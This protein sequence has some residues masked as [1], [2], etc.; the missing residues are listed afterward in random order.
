MPTLSRRGLLALGGAGAAGALLAACG[1]AVDP[2]ADGDDDGAGLGR[3]LEAEAS[4]AAAYSTRRLGLRPGRGAN[5]RWSSSPT[6]PAGAPSEL[7]GGTGDNEPPPDGGP[8]S[9]EALSAAINLA[10]AAIAAHRAATPGLDS[11]E[12][13]GLATASLAACAA[14]LA[15]VSGFAGEPEAPRAFVTGGDAEPHVAASDSER[16]DHDLVHHL[17]RRRLDGGPVSEA[18]ASRR[19]LLRRGRDR[20]RRGRRRRAPAP[21]ARGR[22][23]GD[24]RGPARL[25]RRGDRARAD[26]GA[27]LRD[28]R[29]RRGQRRLTPTAGGLP[30]PG[31]GARERAAQRH[32]RARLRPARG[33]RLAHRHR[34]LR[35]RRRARRPRPPTGSRTGSAMLGEGEDP[36]QFAR[37]C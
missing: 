27:R 10:N 23:V 26:H 36:E 16:R 14:E 18:A 24:R 2:R 20:G 15:V 17:D 8:D 25:P 5:R 19:E 21:G 4:L 31:A 6:P 1:E 22:P 11:A 32:R 12:A 35:R 30:R 7:G 33:A 3:G 34:R 28:R 37:P 13:R 9:A 29:R